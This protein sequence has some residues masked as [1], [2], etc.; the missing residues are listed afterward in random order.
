VIAQNRN[1]ENH[2]QP[3]G[4]TRQPCPDT[5]PAISGSATGSA[6]KAHR[7][8]STA[9][10][11]GGA[12]AFWSALHHRIADQIAHAP[13]RG[14]LHAYAHLEPGECH[15]WPV[16]RLVLEAPPPAELFGRTEAIR[17]HYR[18]ALTASAGKAGPLAD[19]ARS[20]EVEL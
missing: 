12:D 18:E 13:I 16:L 2:S 6:A 3:T 11:A 10:L 15:G 5:N 1:G 8:S 7:N 19:L 14:W 20:V 17:L 9:Q 4:E